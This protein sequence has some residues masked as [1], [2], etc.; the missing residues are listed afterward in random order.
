MIPGF[1]KIVR[2]NLIIMSSDID[3]WHGFLILAHYVEKQE[4]QVVWL[5]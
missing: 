5:Y 2:D 4:D 1:I 3:C